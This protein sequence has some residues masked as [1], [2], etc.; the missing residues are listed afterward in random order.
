M[1]VRPIWPV[2]G[3]YTSRCSRCGRCV[4]YTDRRTVRGAVPLFRGQA[5]SPS[6]TMSPSPGLRPT[7]TPSGIFIHPATWPQQT[8]AENCVCAPLGTRAASPS[9]T[10]WPGLRL[11]SIPSGILIH[12]AVWPQYTNVSD[13]QEG[14]FSICGMRNGE[15]CERVICGKFNASFSCGMKGKVQ[16]ESMRSVTEMNVC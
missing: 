16:N 6:N 11:S 5:G 9:N 2:H 7:S 13:K 12:L 14:V 3:S 8:W 10:V 1:P 4:V 15:S